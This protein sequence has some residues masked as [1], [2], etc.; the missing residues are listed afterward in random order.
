MCHILAETTADI[1]ILYNYNFY[2]VGQDT[3]S[4]SAI[5]TFFKNGEKY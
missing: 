4:F 2:K 3:I 5:I 1:I